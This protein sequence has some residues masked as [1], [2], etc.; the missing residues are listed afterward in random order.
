MDRSTAAVRLLAGDKEPV[1]FKTTG[2]HILSGL[3]A[4][5]TDGVTPV[6]GDRALVS[7]Q[8]DATQNGIYTGSAG[9]WR[10]APD[11]N[12]PRSLIPG[13]KVHVQEGAD[14]AG[15]VWSLVTNRPNLG[16]DVLV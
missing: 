12:S 5:N 11:S 15:D 4:T 2:N 16:T 6:A 14:H 8:D 13:M 10:R 3:A 1:R 7:E 9:V